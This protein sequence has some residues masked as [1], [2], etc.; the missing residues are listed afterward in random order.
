[1][2]AWAGQGKKREVPSKFLTNTRFQRKQE[3]VWDE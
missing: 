3:E 2:V 1:M